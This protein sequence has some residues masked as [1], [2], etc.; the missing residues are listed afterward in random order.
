[1]PVH[2]RLDILPQAPQK[3][4]DQ[5]RQH[6]AAVLPQRDGGKMQ[7]PQGLRIVLFKTGGKAQQN[8]QKVQQLRNQRGNGSAP[9]AHG[10]KPQLAE[11]QQI[12]QPGVGSHR[13]KA[14]QKGDS[15][16][17][18]AAQPRGQNCA[19][20]HREIGER[21][22]LKIRGARLQNPSIGGVKP[23]NLR[24]EAPDSQQKQRRQQSPANQA[25]VQAAPSLPLVV[26]A[27]ELSNQ[28]SGNG[29]HRAHHHRKNQRK[30]AAK[31]HR[32]NIDLAQL[33]DHNLIDN[34]KRRLQHTL[35]RHRHGNFA[36]RFHKV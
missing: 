34:G 5:N 25:D 26:R 9:N 16:V 20:R 2:R 12:V 35:Q 7:R 28:N 3:L 24:G 11:Y 4:T 22:D 27:G 21:H 19:E 33:P 8:Q 13:A 18:L 17:V 1:M 23:Q 14:C 29:T 32:R 36:Q 10:G 30:I 15:G 31:P 6:H